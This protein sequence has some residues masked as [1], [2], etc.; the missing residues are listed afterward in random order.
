M[1]VSL[2]P[3][4]ITRLG[5]DQ[6]RSLLGISFSQSEDVLGKRYLGQN[7]LDDLHRFQ[8]R[9]YEQSPKPSTEILLNPESATKDLN[10]LLERLNLSREDLYW[11]HPRAGGTLRRRVVDLLHSNLAIDNSLIQILIGPRQVG[12]TTAVEHLIKEWNAETHYA[13]A[14]AVVDDFNSWL[15]QQWSIALQKGEGTLLVLD[16][17]QKLEN[18]REHVKVLWDKTRKRGIKVVLL[19]STSLADLLG[20]EKQESLAGRFAPIYVPHWSFSET[21]EAFGIDAQTYSLYGGYPKAME[22]VDNSSRWL[23]YIG[24]SIINP[25]IDVDIFQQGNFRNITY[26]RRAFRVFCEHASKEINYRQCLREIQPTGNIDI[27][28]RY[29]NGY[30]DSFLMS[31]VPQIDNKGHEDPRQ[32]PILMLNCPAVYTF[33]RSSE[34]DFSSDPVRFQQ[35]VASEL[36]RIPHV[37]FGQWKGTSSEVMDLFIRTTDNQIFGVMVEGLKR[38]QSQSKGIE[39]FRKTFKNARVASINP[40]NYTQFIKGQRA[41]L[42]LAS[43]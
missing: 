19:G 29:L 4:A 38:T 1:A 6:V 43:I 17:I 41:F 23:E 3:M 5:I 37:A 7:Q 39:A 12:K 11:I 14:D 35:V 34:E 18:W 32:N 33:G 30:F 27:V 36:Y 10:N 25:I 24:R 21:N 2:K 20:G 8:I 22:F 26:L 42:E 15:E 9:I 40:E 13:S 31:P 16:E 28:K